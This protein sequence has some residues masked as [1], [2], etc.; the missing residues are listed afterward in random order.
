MKKL[1]MI[2]ELVKQGEIQ[3]ALSKLADITLLSHNEELEKVFMKRYSTGESIVQLGK[4]N[5]DCADINSDGT[6]YEYNKVNDGTWMVINV[7]TESIMNAI[8]EIEDI[9]KVA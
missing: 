7:T 1:E 5:K 9:L 4:L 2:K 8:N 3:K 6:V